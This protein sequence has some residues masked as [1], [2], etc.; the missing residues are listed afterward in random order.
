MRSSDLNSA[1]NN[2]VQLHGLL[3]HNN[4]PLL[5]GQKANSRTEFF[6][7]WRRSSVIYLWTCGKQEML[8]Q[9][10]PCLQQV[11]REQGPELGPFYSTVPAI[12][13]AQEH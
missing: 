8:L 11:Q 4:P 9:H 5:K 2:G 13:L 10:C 12:I 3:L 7:A 1:E 6:G